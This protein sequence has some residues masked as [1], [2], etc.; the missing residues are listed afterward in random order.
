MIF[1]RVDGIILAAGF[2]TRLRPLTDEI[3]KAVVEVSGI[4]LIFYALRNMQRAGVSRVVITTHY[5]HEKVVEKVI[6]EKWPFQTIFSHE[7]LI[8]GTGGG[9]KQALQ[10]LPGSE[11]VLVQNADALMEP[12]MSEL[13]ESHFRARALSTMVLKTVSD[14]DEYGAVITDSKDRV[15]EISGRVGYRGDAYQR[16]MFCGMQM[17]DP[18]I[19]E[20]MPDRKEFGIIDEAIVPAIK[21]NAVVIGVENHGFFCDVGTIDRLKLAN[22]HYAKANREKTSSDKT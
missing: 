7:P 11:G 5:L 22:S 6:S 20:F 12:D 8:L 16:R 15:Q 1:P 3:P 9:I 2:G 13:I 10:Y 18:A 21:K 14:P 19:I 17:L 4:P